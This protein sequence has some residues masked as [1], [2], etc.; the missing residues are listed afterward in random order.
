M[1]LEG[2]K[3]RSV[4]VMSLGVMIFLLAAL[5]GPASRSPRHA[6][7]SNSRT[8]N[9]RSSTRVDGR[10]PLRQPA[11]RPPAA[12]QGR[13]DAE[14]HPR[15]LLGAPQKLTYY[16]DILKYYRALAAATPRVKVET[17]GRSDE[18]RELVVVWVCS[19][20]N[21]KALQANRDRLAKLADP[22]GLSDAE[23]GS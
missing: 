22:R 11:R 14:G 12:R 3:R 8:R 4:W 16:A 18:G 1:K 9:S 23:S 17:I 6:T 20:Q 2:T 7:R 10:G 13:A 21:M 5:V 15:P 19:E